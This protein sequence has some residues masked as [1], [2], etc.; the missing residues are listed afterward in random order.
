MRIVK[1][2]SVEWLEANC[3]EDAHEAYK[4]FVDG[5]LSDIVWIC[6]TE[7]GRIL[8]YHEEIRS[9]GCSWAIEKE[10]PKEENPEYYL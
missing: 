7:I 1:M 8:D 9:D 5:Q 6:P 3:Y 10:I 4:A 2:R